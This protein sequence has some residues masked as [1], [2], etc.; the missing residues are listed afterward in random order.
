MW[1]LFGKGLSFGPKSFC[2]EENMARKHS[3]EMSNFWSMCL[4]ASIKVISKHHDIGTRVFDSC[5]W[6]LGKVWSCSKSWC[7]P[8]HQL[9]VSFKNSSFFC[10]LIFEE[11]EKRFVN[12]E[13]YYPLPKQAW[14]KGSLDF[15][16]LCPSG[17]QGFFPKDFKVKRSVYQDGLTTNNDHQSFRNPH[18][19]KFGNIFII[20]LFFHLLFK[21]KYHPI[22]REKTEWKAL[23]LYFF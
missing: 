3:R 22:S 6:S 13:F 15:S 2:S 5:F 7:T 17:H 23:F 1:G 9:S 10:C 8:N 20:F 14:S 16:K 19:S 11:F 12:Q 21:I 4:E 18:Y